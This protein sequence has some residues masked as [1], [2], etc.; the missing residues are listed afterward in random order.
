MKN[1]STYGLIEALS[2]FLE[3]EP[4]IR[5]GGED[6]CDGCKKAFQE[7]CAP[8]V[9]YTPSVPR[10]VPMF[11]LRTQVWDGD[12]EQDIPAWTGFEAH[13]IDRR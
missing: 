11:D 2:D 9:V 6:G 5:C 13:M 12:T 7:T 8:K 4:T 1:G 3:E 10:D